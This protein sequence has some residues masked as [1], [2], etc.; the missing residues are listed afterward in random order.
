MYR[1]ITKMLE[2]QNIFFMIMRTRNAYRGEQLRWFCRYPFSPSQKH[3]CNSL[4]IPKEGKKVIPHNRD[5][6]S[7]VLKEVK[8][9]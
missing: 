5:R 2:K 7:E 6:K 1:K 8:G 9:K 3:L 4:N